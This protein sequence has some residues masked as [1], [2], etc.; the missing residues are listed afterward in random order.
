MPAGKALPAGQWRRVLVCAVSCL[1]GG[2]LGAMVRSQRVAGSGRRV[3]PV[4]RRSKT[5]HAP[6]SFGGRRDAYLQLG[7]R[8]FDGR[9]VAAPAVWAAGGLGARWRPSRAVNRAEN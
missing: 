1:P 7:V 9:A 5:W 4:R 2:A 3:L 8:Q 6:C